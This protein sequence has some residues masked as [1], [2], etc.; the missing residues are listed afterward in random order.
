MWSQLFLIFIGIVGLSLFI[1][2]ESLNR[3][4]QRKKFIIFITFFLILQSGLRNVAIGADTYEYSKRFAYYGYCSWN[5]L[6]EDF[7]NTIVGVGRDAGY[8]LINKAVYSVSSEFQVFLFAVAIFFFSILGRFIYRYT[9]SVSQV[10]LILC[11]YQMFFYTFFSITGIR[12]TIAVGFTLWSFEYV[13]K[14]KVLPFLLLVLL[15][16]TI[17]KTALIF[18]PFYWL[19]KVKQGRM[20]LKGSLLALP[21]L[22]VMA[23]PF[24]RFLADLSGDYSTYAESTYANAGGP[25]YLIMLLLISTLAYINFNYLKTVYNGVYTPFV[26]A[27]AVTLALSPLVWIDPTLLRLSYYYS[28]FILGLFPHLIEILSA[29]YHPSQIYITVAVLIVVCFLIIYTGSYYSFFWQPTELGSNY[30]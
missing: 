22:F 28:V 21:F 6:F 2:P 3:D 14:R 11:F 26:N 15:A 17:H 24:A 1:S 25:N 7:L 23:R 18:I 29:K 9:S 5:T 8:G 30:R 20:V 13:D 12:Q 27:L 10:F 16:A 19:A 4:R